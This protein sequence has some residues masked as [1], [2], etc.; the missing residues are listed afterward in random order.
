MIYCIVLWGK[1]HSLDSDDVGSTGSGEEDCRIGFVLGLSSHRTGIF[2]WYTNGKIVRTVSS[3]VG[4]AAG[5]PV[6]YQTYLVRG[7]VEKKW[8]VRLMLVGMK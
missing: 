1:V 5:T 3:I 8:L 7:R 6:R 2:D 4:I